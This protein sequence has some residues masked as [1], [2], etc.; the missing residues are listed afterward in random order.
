MK[1]LVLRLFRAGGRLWC[2][3]RGCE[4]GAGALIHGLPSITKKGNGR[5]ILGSRV[6]INSS[7]WSNPL[8]TSGST[9][10]FAASGAVLEIKAGA[11]ISSSQLVANTGI[12][13]GEDSLIGAGSLICDSDMHEVPL[14]CGKETRMAPIRI[15]N[16]V[17]IGARSIILKGV[18]IG[19]GAVVA[20]GSVVVSDVA[21][22]SLVAGNPAKL[23]KHFDS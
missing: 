18:S 20:A 7:L 17:F 22:K 5:I 19:E 12:E 16:G 11:G 8:N 4:L 1:N 13:I 23:V 15:G 21:A 6:T 14:G 10:L 3:A 9:R 2:K